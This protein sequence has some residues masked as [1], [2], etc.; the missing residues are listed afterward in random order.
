LAYALGEAA[1]AGVLDQDQ[2]VC[3]AA[4]SAGQL[5]SVT[6]QPGTRV[7]AYCTAN[8]RVLLAHLPQ[9]GML[10]ETWHLLKTARQMER[11]S[12][13]KGMAVTEF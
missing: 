10:R 6:L 12:R 8:G 2:L 11:A 9:L 5:V 13:P 7:P 4:V 3:V 1:S